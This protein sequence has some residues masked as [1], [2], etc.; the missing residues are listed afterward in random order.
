[1]VAKNATKNLMKLY[2]PKVL[3]IYIILLYAK[4]GWHLANLAKKFRFR[5]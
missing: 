3:Y 2:C 1:M 4:I 5:V